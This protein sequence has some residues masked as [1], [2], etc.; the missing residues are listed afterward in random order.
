MRLFAFSGGYGS[1]KSTAIQS[2]YNWTRGRQTVLVKFA[3]PLYDIQEFI[4]SRI[5][6]AHQRP[7]DFVK[8]RK[9][10]Q[11]L[12]TE[13]G[14]SVDQNLWVNIWKAKLEEIWALHPDAIIVCDDCRFDNEAEVVHALGGVVI[15]LDRKNSEQH[16]QGGTGFGKAH[17]SEAGLSPEL[18]DFIVDNNSTLEDFQ[19]SLHALFGE[20]SVGAS[21]SESA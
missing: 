11:W 17:A 7:A 14:R 6:G 9:L 13:W 18:I 2:L 21:R 3:Q 20:L 1:G 15:K 4:Y 19:I 5:A 12:G 10:L 16:A 8:D